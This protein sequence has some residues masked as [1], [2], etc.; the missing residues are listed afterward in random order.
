MYA[1]KILKKNDLLTRREAAF[2]MEER[3]ALVITKSSEWM[4]TLYSAFQDDDNLYLVME[5]A[6][7]GSLRNFMNSREDPVPEEQARFY[8]AE[9]LVAVEELHCIKY[10]HRYVLFE[11]ECEVMGRDIKP[12]N[13]LIDRFGHIKLADFGSCTRLDDKRRVCSSP[14]PCVSDFSRYNRMKPWAHLITFLLRC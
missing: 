7:G 11:C 3:D 5:Y 1:M 4:T 12:E 13:C 14:C 2:F 6:P 9:I 10:I 8:V